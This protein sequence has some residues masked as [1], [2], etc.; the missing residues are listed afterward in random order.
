M[1]QSPLEGIRILDF[2]RATAGPYGSL[3]LADLGATVIRIEDPGSKEREHRAVLDNFVGEKYGFQIKGIGSHFLALD[4]NKESVALNMRSEKG[5]EIF[6]ELVAKSDIVYSNYRAGVHKKMGI[7]YESLSKINPRIITC[8]ITGFGESGPLANR[9]SF[10]T[11]GQAMGGGMSLT[12]NSDG[13]P[14][15]PAIPYADLGA[16]LFAAIGILAAMHAR[17]KTGK[18]QEISVSILD[19]QISLLIY[20]VTDYFASGEVWG[21]AGVGKRAD[22]TH[23]WYKCKDGGYIVVA[24]VQDKWFENMCKVIGREDLITDPKF[25]KAE[26]RAQNRDQLLPMLDE[27]FITRTVSEW[28]KL[29]TEAGVPCGPVNTI[30]QALNN[31]Q[32]IHQDMVVTCPHPLGGEFKAAGNPIKISGHGQLKDA[33][34]LLGQHTVKYLRDLLGYSQEKLTELKK[35]GIIGYP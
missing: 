15:R 29:L 1:K 16:G 9:A 19:G 21:P 10:D 33:P 35:E 5:R 24:A 32:V 34:P 8:S 4:R 23:G 26:T 31:P 22:A 7:D 6:R 11:I 14:I 30:D 18:G 2:S 25:N 3:L 17:E 20:M 12:T 13:Y 28:D 27:V